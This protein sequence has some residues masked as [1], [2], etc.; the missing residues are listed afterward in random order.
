MPKRRVFSL[1]WYRLDAD[2]LTLQTVNL[3]AWMARPCRCN[4]TVLMGFHCFYKISCVYKTLMCT[5]VK[6]CEA[7]AKKLYI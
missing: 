3:E 7:L 5:C 4:L 6:P 1:V 2:R